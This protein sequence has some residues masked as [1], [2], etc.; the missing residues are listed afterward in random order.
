MKV[1]SLSSG[2]AVAVALLAVGLSAPRLLAQEQEP[3]GRAVELGALSGPEAQGIYD[4]LVRS[5]LFELGYQPVKKPDP[6]LSAGLER[7][8]QYQ[9]PLAEK[10]TR[11]LLV[12]LKFYPVQGGVLY[13]FGRE[14]LPDGTTGPNPDAALLAARARKIAEQA[15][16]M[17]RRYRL[18]ELDSEIYQVSCI[19]AG[20]CLE[21]LTAMGYTT[22]PP[23]GP[24][25]LSGLPALF[26]LAD[27]KDDSVVGKRD[28]LNVATDSSP[29]QRLI[30][31]YHPSQVAELAELKRLLQEKIDVP[32]RQVLIEAM[33]IELSESASRELGMQYEAA[34]PEDARYSL[35][36]TTEGDSTPFLF[37]LSRYVAEEGVDLR[38]LIVTL[39]AI[40][41]ERGGEVLSSPSVLTLDNRQARFTIT[42]DVPVITTVVTES[43][44][45]LNVSYKTVGI[46]LNIKPRISEDGSWVTLQI[47]TEVSEA[48]LEDF[49]EVQGQ[50]LAPVI[51][52]RK[53][54]TIA[55][56]RNNTPFIIGGLIRDEQSEKVQRIPIIS[57]I[58]IIGNLFQVRRVSTGKREVIIVLTP[59]VIET[60]GSQRSV[61]PTDTRRFDLLNN[62]LFRNSY[63]LK[64][65]DVFDL[66]FVTQNL[67]IQTTLRR[68]REF[69][70]THPERRLTPP[71]DAVAN[72]KV[73]G[74]EAFVVRM[75]Y[76]VV[77][78][79][80]VHEQ[81]ST[82]RM[83]Y[84]VED[85]DKP[86]GF[87]IEYLDDR[88]RELAAGAEVSEYLA[89]EFPKEV[90]FLRYELRG[91]AAGEAL[92]P[93]VS[94]EVV[95]MESEEAAEQALR[96]Y[97]RIAE[98]YHRRKAAV[99]VASAKDLA[100]LKA[101]L[102]IREVVKVN[103]VE[104]LLNLEH[105]RVG[106][107]IIMPDMDPTGD[108]FF[109]IDGPTAEYFFLS[110][111]YYD[112]F[113]DEF[114]RYYEGI[115][116]VL[117]NEK[118]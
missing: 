107:R 2:L 30:I 113:Q 59:R 104:A 101:A 50:R 42:D 70:A 6:A 97:G 61:L 81:V 62:R 11:M 52:R 38:R 118:P 92:A 90:L 109:L 85:P 53:V 60:T 26:L 100:R 72:G 3:L 105:F 4:T 89:Q 29:Q 39:K 82:E 56:I 47:Q 108:R 31:L 22:G 79:V 37:S 17:E 25:P 103:G 95:R 54:E 35:S 67:E 87:R 18:R 12:G 23:T 44:S 111:F 84:F 41:D 43:T 116:D 49:I 9:R 77:Q 58:P 13:L 112:A 68:A 88:L 32:S 71:F 8:A 94:A 91:A 24:L 27:T 40:I 7:P 98:G 83:I 15:G 63:R 21:I 74:E 57:R 114:R 110:D 46:I 73:P 36:F 117:A 16:A 115:R 20:L 106:R 10:H 86:T 64:A 51:N 93:V 78:K 1:R 99:L 66:G 45:S 69:L 75:L 48:P 96:E 102:A 28:A 65:E 19:E 55:R 76:E 33:I 34:W 5:A 14:S 80:D